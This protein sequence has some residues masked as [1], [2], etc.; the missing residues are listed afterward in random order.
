MTQSNRLDRFDS[1][2]K[3]MSRRIDR[4]ELTQISP[5]E[6]DRATE[7][8]RRDLSLLRSV[9]AG[10]REVADRI[11]RNTDLKLDIILRQITGEGDR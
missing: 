2:L 3:E 6:L 8:V 5:Q 10:L 7:L 1:Q 11:E 4:L 9:V